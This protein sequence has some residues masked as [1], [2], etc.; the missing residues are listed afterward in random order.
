MI[1]WATLPRLVERLDRRAE[2]CKGGLG[3]SLGGVQT[4]CVATDEALEELDAVL[5]HEVDALVPRQ[6][7]PLGVDLGDRQPDDPKGV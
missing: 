6:Q 4:R 3:F 2:Q 1:S 7:C 5:V